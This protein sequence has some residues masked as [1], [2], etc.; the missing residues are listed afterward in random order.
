MR[1]YYILNQ[2]P[3]ALAVFE[4]IQ[5]HKLTVSIHLNRTRFLVPKD[6]VILTELLLRFGHCVAQ[7]ELTPL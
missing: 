7:V 4:F 2:D 3:S 6:S 1:H 5:H